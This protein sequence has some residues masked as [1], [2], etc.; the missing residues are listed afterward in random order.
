[1]V[2]SYR[3]WNCIY[4]S[5]LNLLDISDTEHV[6]ANMGLP[7]EVTLPIILLEII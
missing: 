2:L 6:F 4:N 1:M 3:I 7:E 5:W